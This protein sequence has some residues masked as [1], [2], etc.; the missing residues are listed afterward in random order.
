M[1]SCDW[2]YLMAPAAVWAR[3]NLRSLVR[4]CKGAEGPSD[5]SHRL[6]SLFMPYLKTT[7]HPSSLP[8][9]FST[10]EHVFHLNIFFAGSVATTLGIS[11]GSTTVAPWRFNAAIASDITFIWSAF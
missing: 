10:P 8:F 6:K 3:L 9:A 7:E 1:S 5:A 11:A 2:P 4:E